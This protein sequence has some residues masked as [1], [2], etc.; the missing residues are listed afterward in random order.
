MPLSNAKCNRGPR[1]VEVSQVYRLD[2]AGRALE[3]V[4]RHHLGT[5][6]LRIH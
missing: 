5:L 4:G 6:A 2:E 3:A 1:H